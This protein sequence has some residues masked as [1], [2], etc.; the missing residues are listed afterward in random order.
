MKMYDWWRMEFNEA[1]WQKIIIIAGV[2]ESKDRIYK[3]MLKTSCG[4][5]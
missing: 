4:G 3:T 5:T 2:D 1:R